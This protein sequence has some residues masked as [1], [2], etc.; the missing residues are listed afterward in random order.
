MATSYFAKNFI[1]DEEAAERLAEVLEKPAPPRPNIDK[2]FW[3]ENE[4][5]KAGWLLSNQKET[6]NKN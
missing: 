5:K 3:E 2:N 1:L 4:R 6:L